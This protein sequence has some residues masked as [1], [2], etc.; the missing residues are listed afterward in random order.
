VPA[1]VWKAY[2]IV[3]ELGRAV[4]EPP[5]THRFPWIFTN[6]REAWSLANEMTW[7][8]KQD[9]E[10]YHRYRVV[11]VTLTSDEVLE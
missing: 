7:E 8:S 5:D 3:D 11:R 1:F 10:R 4:H 6:K 2:M 9:T